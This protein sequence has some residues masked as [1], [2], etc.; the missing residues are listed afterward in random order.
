M[1]KGLLAATAALG[2]V[3]AAAAYAGAPSSSGPQSAEDAL[4][5]CGTTRTIG[6]LAPIT[7]PA[8]SLGAT[9]VK[10]V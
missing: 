2:L 10:W 9:Q 5:T 6:L 8:A 1:R 3:V 4:V 7:G